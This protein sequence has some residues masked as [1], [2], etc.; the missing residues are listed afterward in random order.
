MELLQKYGASKAMEHVDF[1]K[2]KIIAGDH[3]D[4]DVLSERTRIYSINFMSIFI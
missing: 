3:A 4:L 2:G 1:V